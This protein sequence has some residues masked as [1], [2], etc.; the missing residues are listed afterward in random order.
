MTSVRNIRCLGMLCRTV[1][2]AP[3]FTVQDGMNHGVAKLMGVTPTP[4]ENLLLRDTHGNP[5][6]VLALPAIR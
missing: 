5:Y 1:G 6:L 4:R 3:L 2:H